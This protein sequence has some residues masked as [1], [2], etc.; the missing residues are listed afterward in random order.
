MRLKLTDGDRQVEL[1]VDGDAPGTLEAAEQCALRLLA[2][3]APGPAASPPGDEVPFG[4][5]ATADTERADPH[6]L[7]DPLEGYAHGRPR[8]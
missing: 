2:A 5:S 6:L 7:F 3:L 8:A 4:Y 1:V